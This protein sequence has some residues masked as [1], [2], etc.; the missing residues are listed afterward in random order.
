MTAYYATMVDLF[1]DIET[2]PDMEA[3][4][5]L[6]AAE[7]IKRGELGPSS[8]DS[9][10]YWK[11]TRGAL[12][13]TDGRVMLITYQINDAPTRRLKEWE[14]GERVVL[15]KFYSLLQNLQR[16]RSSDSLRIIGH[17]ILAFD[18]FFLYNR[19]RLHRLDEEAWLSQW[20]VNGPITIDF[21]QMH[22]PLNGMSAKGLKHDVLMHAYGLPT[23]GSTGDDEIERYF[24]GD[25]DHVIGYS[26]REFV[27]PQLFRKITEGGLVSAQKLVD[28][29]R[30]YE[31]TTSPDAGQ[32]SL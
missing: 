6:E 21:L 18:M 23:K 20:V 16:H 17:N 5:Y 15:E 9:H 10:L 29:I 11:C 24:R 32:H 13:Y 4:E 19:M 1:V 3:A 12:K 14:A 8:Q 31:A 26:E 7:R 25:Y 30:W 27:Y 22:L 2:I 28:S